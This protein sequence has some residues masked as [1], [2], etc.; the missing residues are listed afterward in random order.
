M[1]LN[2]EWSDIGSWESV[3]ETSKKDNDNNVIE[4]NVFIKDTQNTYIRS[5]NRLV[6]GIG[7]NNLVV[8][9]TDDAILISDKKQ[10][11][12]NKAMVNV[13]NE[14]N[15]SAGSQHQKIYRPWGHY[16]SVVEKSRWQV[17]LIFV[18]PG[19]A[20]HCKCIIIVLNIG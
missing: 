13:L 11:Q 19:K 15:I 20:Y 6:V 4:G 1:P 7:L 16:L 3:W 17:K 9:E 12:K 2:C 10:T 14:K 8:V 5:E 18:K